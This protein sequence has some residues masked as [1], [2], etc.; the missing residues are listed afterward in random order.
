MNI[1]TIDKTDF[2]KGASTT[3]Y[4]D[5]G[6][7]SPD[8]LGIEIN[9]ET[10]LGL[11]LAGRSLTL[12]TSD[13]GTTTLASYLYNLSGTYNYYSIDASGKIYESVL[14]SFATTVKA[15]EAVKTYS[16]LTDIIVYNNSLFI[17]S[18]TDIL[19]SDF[20]FTGGDPDHDWWTATLSKT[21]LTS[22]VMHLLFEFN[23]ILYITNGNKLASWDGATAKDAV[24]TL[25][26][27][28]TI[29]AVE[30]LNNRI[31][32]AAVQG[33]TSIVAGYNSPVKIFVW[34]GYSASWIDEKKISTGMITAMKEMDGL[35][36]FFANS[37]IYVF[38][39]Y[40]Y[41]KLRYFGVSVLKH[42]ISAYNS[43]LYFTASGG[44]ACYDAVY[45]SFSFPIKTSKSVSIL[46]LG[47][48]SN[49]DLITTEGK[50]Y[51]C[52]TNSD[53]VSF[54]SN[55]F[56]FSLPVYIRKIDIL[57][58]GTLDTGDTFD[59]KLLN[60]SDTVINTKTISRAVDGAIIKKTY[61]LNYHLDNFRLRVDLN[62]TASYQSI[63]CIKI[64][65]EPSERVNSK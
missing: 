53:I 10:Y 34:D 31:Y 28:W 64:Y 37:S 48:S 8:S 15:T 65:Y 51:R 9:N 12:K 14:S 20:T 30:I 49:I 62:S 1:I 11:L 23:G 25:P 5:D 41:R 4:L 13:L 17:T 56:T 54:Y 7:F 59:I 57:F 27:G 26:T 45:K 61:S 38:D 36:Y 63:K 46:K 42:Q 22:T 35:I 19:K 43:K 24:L 21:A 32:L 29:T 60:E 40:S 39:G 16:S 58:T 33:T 44:I 55:S 18:T 50:G 3:K 47:V 6:G 52:S 2:L